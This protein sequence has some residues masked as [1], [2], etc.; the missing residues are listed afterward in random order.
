[1]KPSEIFGRIKGICKRMGMKTI[2]AGCAVLV[3]CG[4]IALNLILQDEPEDATANKLAVDLTEDT[5]Q[6]TLAADEVQDYF[7]SISVQRKQARDE[8][9]EVLASVAGSETALE[10]AKQAALT[11]MNK[12]ALE[13]EQEANIETLVQ[14]KGFQQCVAVINNDKCSV[15]VETTGLMPGEV[16]QI[17]EIV[18]EQ[19][20]I[21]PENLKI[22]ERQTDA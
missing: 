20:G 10:E 6:P 2:I 21:V 1:M 16:A 4:A 14:S 15:I 5:V 8:A 18:Y 17:S 7:A 3:L 11:D 12:L 19:T 9:I 22:I 13:I